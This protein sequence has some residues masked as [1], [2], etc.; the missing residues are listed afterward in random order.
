MAPLVAMRD[1]GVVAAGI[2]LFRL[3]FQNNDRIATALKQEMDFTDA[4]KHPAFHPRQ[5]FSEV[6]AR[7]TQRREHS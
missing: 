3:Q 6:V 1:D 2:D 7:Q 5:I 4:H